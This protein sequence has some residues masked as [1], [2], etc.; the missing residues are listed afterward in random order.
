MPHHFYIPVMGTGFTADTPIRVSHLG[1]DSAISLV[2]DKLLERIGLYY[3]Q[4]F[5][6]PY[7]K[8]ASSEKHSRAERIRR[9]LN[10]IH[11]LA[12]K[13]FERTVAEPFTGNSD[14]D[15]YFLLL[16]TQDPLR[17][18]YLQMREMPAGDERIKTEKELTQKMQPGSIDVNIMVKLDRPDFEDAREAL[19]GYAESTLNGNTRLILSAGI[20]QALFS[21]MEK[22]PC[23]YRNASGQFDKK[24]SLKVSD[25]R[26]ALI[27]GKTLA[28]KGLEVSEYRVESGLNCGGHLFP[29]QGELLPVILQ[30]MQEKKELLCSS[31]KPALQKYYAAH[32]LDSSRLDKPCTP[33][34]SVQGGI[35]NAQEAEFLMRRF[36]FDRCGWG[37]PF[38]L[39]PEAT[40]VDTSTRE[41]LAEANEN[42]IWM[43]NASPLDVP[44]SNLKSSG[45]EQNRIRKIDMGIFGSD[46]P[47]GFLQN[48]TEFSERL[49]CT[50][51]KEY[52]KKKIAEILS[53]D[54]PDL[55]KR[56]QIRRVQ[57]KS[58]ICH[59]LG[60]SALISLGIEREEI[61]PQAICPGPNI[62]YFDRLYTLSEMVDF[63]YGRKYDLISSQRPNLFDQ[64]ISLYQKWIQSEKSKS[65]SE[66]RESWLKTA[67]ENLH[68][69][70][71]FVQKLVPEM[72]ATK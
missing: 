39:V 69:G 17:I 51:S 7:E 56:E 72:Q 5:A 16:P 45:S 14:K 6:I 11:I 50:A 53:K 48:N 43:S 15:R 63:I 9:Y 67:E 22:F 42:D 2:D 57:E 54:I 46:C 21:E 26:S 24:I 12:Q 10:L 47:K 60:N 3:A 30:E 66:A 49:I 62:A 33:L 52:Q 18:Q 71:E 8:V 28:R 1:I 59:E 44:F 41:K 38:L 20:N 58:C 36:G 68:R 61:A 19:R 35:G 13:K 27:Q 31:L 65:N 55:Q 37:T 23:F 40:L 29:S 32:H 25:F 64:E 4:K 70:M 34:F